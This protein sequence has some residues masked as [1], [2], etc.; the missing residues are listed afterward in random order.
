MQYADELYGPEF[1]ISELSSSD[2]EDSTEKTV[3]GEEDIEE[4]IAEEVKALKGQRKKKQERRFQSVLSGAKNV[5]FV[6]CR[7]PVDPVQLVHRI[8]SDV[9]VTGLQKTR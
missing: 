4:S 6:E 3:S 7:A 2:D 5:V 9:K 8:L 1:P